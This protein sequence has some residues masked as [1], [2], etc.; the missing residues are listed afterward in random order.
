MRAP[1]TPLPELSIDTPWQMDNM[2]IMGRTV[3]AAV[4]ERGA[5]GG[6]AKFGGDRAPGYDDHRSAGGGGGGGAGKR[7]FRVEVTGLPEAYSWR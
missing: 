3:K 4:A 2:E 1:N 5:G 7:G 6:G